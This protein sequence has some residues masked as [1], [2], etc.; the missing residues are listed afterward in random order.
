MYTILHVSDLHRTGAGPISNAELLSGLIAD[1]ERAKR[2][3][4]SIAPPDAI[5]VSGDLIEGLPIGS[6]EYPEDLKKQ[7]KEAEELLVA[8]TNEFLDGDR[9]RVIIVPGNHDVDWNCARSA[10]SESDDPI[11]ARP[12][13]TKLDTPYRW[14][15]KDRRMYKIVDS[16]RYEK[17]FAYFIEMY[18]EFYRDVQLDFPIDPGKPW[19]LFSLDNGNIIIS[20]F[21][22]CVINDCYS[23]IG[24]IRSE[25]LA[26]CHLE[27]RR[28][29]RRGCLP[30]AVW[31]HGVGGPP[32][33][34]DYVDPAT[35]K[36]M[37]DKGF[38]I[39]LH[40]HRHDSTHSP[41]ELYVST[42]ETMAVIGAGSLSAG[43][44][45]LPHGV[46]RRYNIIMIER[47]N[48]RGTVHVREMNQPNIWG[49][50]QLFESGGKSYVSAGWTPSSID[51]VDQNKSGGSIIVQLDEV[52][53]LIGLGQLIEARRLLS[54]DLDINPEYRRLLLAKILR[55][56]EEWQELKELL[57]CPR[58]DEELVSFV[59]ASERIGDF[60]E[61]DGV[62]SRAEEDGEYDPALISE[63]K[64]RVRARRT[65]RG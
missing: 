53:R 46:N 15:W 36:L 40:G 25:D 61:V 45:A 14:S 37:I 51:M 57:S 60:T 48:D 38:R 47:E 23:D 10:L 58:N 29:A 19:N 59:A 31:H 55:Q 27:I 22:S 7:Y 56:S 28:V 64:M 54:S 21:N 13:L 12:S 35:L 1:S 41:V 49:P 50:G 62:L 9:S 26:D 18:D 65:L 52:E 2:E 39:G 63:L 33:T 42:K 11:E 24:H 4:P 16:T 17:R 34:S 3:T 32:L 44:N 20:A 8:L 6:E 30:I 43:L 5:V